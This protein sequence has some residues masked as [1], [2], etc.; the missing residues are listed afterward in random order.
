MKLLSSKMYKI[1]LISL[2]FFFLWTQN[3][4]L[5][6][7]QSAI[8]VTRLC[9][10]PLKTKRITKTYSNSRDSPSKIAKTKPQK[11]MQH[12]IQPAHP[13]TQK[14]TPF[15]RHTTSHTYRHT[16]SNTFQH[17][18]TKKPLSLFWLKLNSSLSLYSDRSLSSMSSSSFTISV[19]S[20]RF[21]CLL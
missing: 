8:G 20:T 7:S 19:K 2:N 16:Q 4:Y 17:K 14:A 12:N 18:T 15:P 10:C 21:L 11:H 9:F 5:T 13:H 3:T 6:H 1:N